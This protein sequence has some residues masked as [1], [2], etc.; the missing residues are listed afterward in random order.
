[1]TS[2]PPTFAA[3]L[4]RIVGAPHVRADAAILL[5]YGTDAL[6][7][8]HPADLVVIPGSPAEISAIARLCHDLRVPLVVRGAGTGYSGGA[9]PTEGGVVLSVERL[10][11]IV[12]IDADNLLAVVQPA[13]ITGELQLAVESQGCFIR[14]IH[15]V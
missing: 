15:R 2:L 11:R 5:E 8:G 1:M 13:V 4:E 10:N 9:V 3:Q 14:P 7:R 12:E 6:K